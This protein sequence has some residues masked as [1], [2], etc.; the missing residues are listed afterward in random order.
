MQPTTIIVGYDG[1]PA[2]EDAVALATRMAEPTHARL[3]LAYAY[4][5]DTISQESAERMLRRGLRHLPYG[6]AAAVRAVPESQPAAVLAQLAEREQAE[7][8]V[9]GAST[10]GPDHSAVFVPLGQQL[11]RSASCAIAVAPAGFRNRPPG[12]LDRDL[13]IPPGTASAVGA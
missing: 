7:L 13:I 1:G 12:E 11:A 6:R 8:I 3:V 9:V 2:A 4:R 10:P 5:P